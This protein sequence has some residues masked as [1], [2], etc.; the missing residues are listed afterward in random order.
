ME[1]PQT[2]RALG[3][4]I[5]IVCEAALA[6]AHWNDSKELLNGISTCLPDI[7]KIA[8]WQ[9]AWADNQ[10]Y[11]GTDNNCEAGTWCVPYRQSDE[12]KEISLQLKLKL[13]SL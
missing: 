13:T 9:K 2:V 6:E 3:W 7:R 10:V 8:G 5:H 4:R 11:S 1:Q 12:V